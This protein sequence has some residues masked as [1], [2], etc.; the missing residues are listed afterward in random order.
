MTRTVRINRS[1]LWGS[2][3]ELKEVGGYDDEATA[4]ICLVGPFAGQTD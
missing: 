1:R 4:E 2:L 3:M